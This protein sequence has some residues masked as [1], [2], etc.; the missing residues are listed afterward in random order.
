MAYGYE[1]GVW[2]AAHEAVKGELLGGTDVAPTVRVCDADDVVLASAELDVANAEVDEVGNLTIPI[3]TQE[4][5]APAA[6]T[7]A[8]AAIH[9]GVGTGTLRAQ[10]ACQVGTVA[11]PGYCVINTLSITQ[12]APV[13][14]QS[15]TIAAGATYAPGGN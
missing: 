10:F 11:V 4:L 12:G 2:V 9:D 14:F 6:G 1:V 13:S 8:Y 15:I 7:A 3:A 5:S